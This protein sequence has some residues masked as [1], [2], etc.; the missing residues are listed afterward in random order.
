MAAFVK[1]KLQIRYPNNKGT[2]AT[3]DL[4]MGYHDDSFTQDTLFT[5]SWYFSSRL[6]AANAV[7]QW[8]L[9]PIGGELRPEFWICIFG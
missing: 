6:V 2:I 5:Y 1:T 8:K 9:Y 4:K 3:A 7:N